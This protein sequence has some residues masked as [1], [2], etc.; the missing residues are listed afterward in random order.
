MRKASNNPKMVKGATPALAV[1]T[2]LDR[3]LA[4]IHVVGE[5]V[6]GPLWMTLFESV[7]DAVTLGLLFKIPSLLSKIV[8]NQEFSGLDECLTDSNVWSI[9]RYACGAVVLSDYTLWAALIPRILF[10]FFR[11]MSKL[12]NSQG[13]ILPRGVRAMK[14]FMRRKP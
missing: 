1:A 7:Q 13:A 10:R 11:D 6:L 3:W 8:L 4:V 5:R 14:G 9:S 12:L 2:F